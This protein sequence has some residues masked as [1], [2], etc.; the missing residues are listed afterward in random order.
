MIWIILFIYLIGYIVHFRMF[1]KVDYQLIDG[2]GLVFLA[3]YFSLL[4]WISVIILLIFESK[5]KPPKWLT[6]K[7]K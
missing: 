2:W 6:G 1:M 5:S 3:F 4:S 7:N